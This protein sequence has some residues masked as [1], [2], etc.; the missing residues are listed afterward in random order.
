MI[1]NTGVGEELTLNLPCQSD[2]IP[3]WGKFRLILH[4][5]RNGLKPYV[6][7]N[8]YNIYGKE[9]ANLHIK[10]ELDVRGVY[11]RS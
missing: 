7:K 6:N 8:Y 2:Q 9:E 4:L 11:Y 3:M 10:Q 5:S 1:C